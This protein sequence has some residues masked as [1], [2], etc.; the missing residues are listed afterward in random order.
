[1]TTEQIQAVRAVAD[2]FLEAVEVAGSHGAPEGVMYSAVADKLTLDQFQSI[3]RGLER[4]GAI[5]R[6]G[7]LC[8][9]SRKFSMSEER[10]ARVEAQYSGGAR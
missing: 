9:Y 8:F 3:L 10:N 4:A 6:E 2:M 7:H 1:M 5:R